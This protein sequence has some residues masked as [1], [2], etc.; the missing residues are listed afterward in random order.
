MLEGIIKA[1]DEAIEHGG[2]KFIEGLFEGG[3]LRAFWQAISSIAVVHW[4]LTYWPVTLGGAAVVVW[5]IAKG[6]RP[7]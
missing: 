5:L 6:R 4:M 7:A 2:G 3:E 1:I